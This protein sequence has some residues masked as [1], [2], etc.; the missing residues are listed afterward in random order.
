MNDSRLC[1]PGH[2]AECA[3]LRPAVAA[4]LP[5]ATGFLRCR[6]GAFAEVSPAPTPGKD[7]VSP[8]IQ[9]RTVR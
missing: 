7:R 4:P 6:Y 9:R 8:A 5:C 2:P 1:G 3:G